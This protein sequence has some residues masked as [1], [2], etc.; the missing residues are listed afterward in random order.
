MFN[1]NSCPTAIFSAKNLR[2]VKT[3]KLFHGCVSRAVPVSQKLMGAA[4]VVLSFFSF[5]SCNKQEPHT[6]ESMLKEYQCFHD[7][8]CA[9]SSIEPYDISEVVIRWKTLESNLFDLISQDS[10][11]Y[12]ENFNTV[13]M[14]AEYGNN[15]TNALESSID[16]HLYSYD[17]ILSIQD[18]IASHY[19][20]LVASDQYCQEANTFYESLDGY[21]SSS[22]SS[23][24][25]ENEY[26]DFLSYATERKY[27]D[28]SMMTECLR[29]EDILFRSYLTSM[30]SHPADIAFEIVNGTEEL[31]DYMADALVSDSLA[32]R[33]LLAYM[34]VRTN[35]RLLCCAQTG[36]NYS[37]SNSIGNMQ[38]ASLCV[39]SV[40]APYLQFNPD[41]ISLRTTKQRNML[42]LIGN[43]IPNSFVNLESQGFVLI[44]HPDSLPNRIIKDYISY[45][46][47]Y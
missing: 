32:A 44:S 4:F 5:S 28:W 23:S 27:D 29:T 9:L 11:N 47:N 21:E 41:I 24:A 16:N 2:S 20:Q 39:S 1:F 34:T 46:L 26:L 42:G 31:S 38:Q 22:I 40:I 10:I 36:L 25:I 13:T 30:L 15:I 45:V 43:K 12:L 14:M 8:L 33:R 18:Q 17:D 7:S 3:S 19:A 6:R 35:R 37:L